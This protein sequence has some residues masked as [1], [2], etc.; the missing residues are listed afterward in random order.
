M[1]IN[2]SHRVTVSLPLLLLSP[3]ILSGSFLFLPFLSSSPCFLS[4]LSVLFSSNIFLF[5]FPS[6]FF[7]SCPYTFSIHFSY[8]FFRFSLI[9]SLPSFPYL[10]ESC[11]IPI[12]STPTFSNVF[13]FYEFTLHLIAY[14]FF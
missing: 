12:F 9:L 10:I 3:A 13:L 4:F 6:F 1:L 8:P 11:H 5:S 7:P 14:L 2:D